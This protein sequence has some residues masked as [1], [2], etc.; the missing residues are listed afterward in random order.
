[1]ANRTKIYVTFA[2]HMPDFEIAGMVSSMAAYGD[3]FP[4]SGERRHFVVEVFRASKAPRLRE[5][6]AGWNARGSI[7]WSES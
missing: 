7:Q 4:H 5:L 3:V 1:M 2:E 6:L